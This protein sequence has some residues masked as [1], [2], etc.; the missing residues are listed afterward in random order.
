VSFTG[1]ALLLVAATVGK[2]R[3]IDNTAVRIGPPAERAR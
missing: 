3:L 1:L 2:T